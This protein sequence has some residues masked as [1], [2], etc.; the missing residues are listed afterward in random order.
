MS[1][2]YI[3]K[4]DIIN[5]DIVLG[6][7]SVVPYHFQK[8]GGQKV[9]VCMCGGRLDTLTKLLQSN[10][11]W[12]ASQGGGIIPNTKQLISACG[13]RYKLFFVQLQQTHLQDNTSNNS[14]AE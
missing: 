7:I 13:N 14:V 3:N 2:T 11:S 1:D 8:C 12:H 5:Q 6:Y 10:Y 4:S 9:C